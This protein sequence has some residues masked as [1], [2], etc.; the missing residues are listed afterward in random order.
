MNEKSKQKGIIMIIFI[1]AILLCGFRYYIYSNDMVT[2]NNTEKMIEVADQYIELMDKPD[3]IVGHSPMCEK[4]ELGLM[5]ILV[6]YQINNEKN[7]ECVY[8]ERGKILKNYYHL[9]GA[10]GSDIGEFIADSQIIN[11]KNIVF[12]RGFQ[13]EDIHSFRIDKFNYTGKIENGM[14][15]DVIESKSKDMVYKIRTLK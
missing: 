6:A 10:L 11:D 9:S 1:G 15:L 2:N 8:F 13:I 5:C 12:V 4:K 7:V 14:Y 3:K